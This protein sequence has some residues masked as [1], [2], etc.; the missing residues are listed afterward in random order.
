MGEL[1][2][3]ALTIINL[4]PSFFSSSI[5]KHEAYFNTKPDLRAIRLLLIFSAL[6]VYRHASHSEL[7]SQ[8]DYWQFGL[9]V[10]PSPSIPGAIRAAVLT[11]K[12]QAHIITYRYQER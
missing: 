12:R 11:N 8:H 1:F 2:Y 6:Y 7:Q 3:W 10:G 9:Y 5:T 4:K